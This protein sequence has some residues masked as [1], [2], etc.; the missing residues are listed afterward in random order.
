[1]AFS[2]AFQR[3]AKEAAKF[4]NQIFDSQIAAQK[5]VDAAG[6]PTNLRASSLSRATSMTLQK[7]TRPA[8]IQR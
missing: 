7:P 1:M 3:N 6:T 4:E 8:T 2:Y 5:F